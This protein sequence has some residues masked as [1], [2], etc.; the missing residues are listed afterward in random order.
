VISALLAV[1]AVAAIG[2]VAIGMLRWRYAI[3]TVRGPSMAPDLSDGDRV[4][5]RRCGIRRL[6]AGELVIFREPGRLARPRRPAWLTGANHDVWVIKRIAAIPG[7]PVP[8]AVRP[9]TNGTT[10]VPR[11]SLVVLGDAPGSRDSR[12]WGFVPASYVL[13]RGKRKL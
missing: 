10:V 5:A 1:A 2:A 11:G 9:V 13:G 12:I 3:V 7:D 8:E 4:L 6:R